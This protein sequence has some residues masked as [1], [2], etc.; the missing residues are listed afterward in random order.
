MVHA[1]IASSI[2]HLSCGLRYYIHNEQQTWYI[3]VKFGNESG[4]KRKHQLYNVTHPSPSRFS[5]LSTV[6]RSLS[7]IHPFIY[8]YVLCYLSLLRCSIIHLTRD[9]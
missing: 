5:L 6:N 3:A 9:A 4:K 1:F 7:S 2:V 8:V